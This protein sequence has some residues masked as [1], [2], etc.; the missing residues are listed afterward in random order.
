MTQDVDSGPH[1]ERGNV[2]ENCA[3]EITPEMIREGAAELE[4]RLFDLFGDPSARS[5]E[6]IAAEIYRAMRRAFLR[7]CHE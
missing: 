3:I 6:E 2:P 4:N 1:C 5:R 7:S